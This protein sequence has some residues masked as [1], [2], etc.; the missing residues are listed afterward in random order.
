VLYDE[1]FNKSGGFLSA[2]QYFFALS[3]ISPCDINAENKEIKKDNH[4]YD[5][6]NL[7]IQFIATDKAIIRHGKNTQRRLLHTPR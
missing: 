6:S 7:N 1:I 2:Q 3:E 5:L 4:S